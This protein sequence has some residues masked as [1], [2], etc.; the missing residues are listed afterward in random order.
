M[1]ITI[2]ID[3]QGELRCEATHGPSGNHFHTDAPV[4]NNGKGQSFSPTD[5]V[6]TALAT[7]MATVIGIKA[8]QKGYDLAG[9]KV[10]VEKHM[11][12]DSPRRI[13]RLPVTIEIPLPPDHPDRRLLEATAL[14]CPVHHSV[15]PEID[16]PVTFVWNG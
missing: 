7:C 9:M 11:S 3:Y 2:R 8:R 15:H 10:S 13:T 6:A 4:D 12:A 5:L 16:K 14:G 1:A